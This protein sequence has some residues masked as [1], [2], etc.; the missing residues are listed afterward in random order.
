MSRWSLFP[1]AAGKPSSDW[2]RCQHSCIRSRRRC[3]SASPSDG[4]ITMVQWTPFHSTAVFAMTSVMGSAPTKTPLC[5]FSMPLP[6]ARLACPP[7]TKDAPPRVA[8][9]LLPAAVLLGREV[10]LRQD[11]SG[12]SDRNCRRGR[13]SPGDGGDQNREH[14]RSPRTNPPGFTSPGQRLTIPTTR[15]DSQSTLNSSRFPKP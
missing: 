13:W 9:V 15:P 3:T 7:P 4:H 12:G 5:A 14:H 6:S 2:M 11:S 8:F 10:R 1:F